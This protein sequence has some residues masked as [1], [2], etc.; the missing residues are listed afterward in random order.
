M[1]IPNCLEFVRYKNVFQMHSV[2]ATCAHFRLHYAHIKLRL[3]VRPPVF[4][5][6]YFNPFHKTVF[7]LA[8]V[9]YGVE[10]FLLSHIIRKYI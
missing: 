10:H 8:S 4:A 3:A 7:I 6:R 5:I 1:L 9:V 2:R